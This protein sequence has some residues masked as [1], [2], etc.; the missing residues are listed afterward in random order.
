MPLCRIALLVLLGVMA[1]LLA[2]PAN[3]AETTDLVA[4]EA[5][6]KKS[7]GT[8]HVVETGTPARQGPNLSAVFGSKA[9]AQEAFPKY[10]EALKKAGTDGLVWDETTLDSWITNAAKL[11]PGSVMP[12]RQAD[13]VKRKLVIDYLKSLVPAKAP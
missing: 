6:F 8:C 7:C 13:A 4:A 2:P 10:S 11:V 3:A 5:Q 12:Y 1:G 9:G